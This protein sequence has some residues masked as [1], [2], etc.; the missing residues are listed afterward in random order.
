[1]IEPL[2]NNTHVQSV[3]ITMAEAFDV[4]DRGRFYDRTGAIRDVIQ[5]H[6]FQVLTNLAMEPPVRPDS[7]S[8]RD[9]KVKVLKAM[10]PLDPQN[11]VRGQFRG[12]R[13][14]T[15]W[16]RIRRSRPSLPCG[17]TSIP[18]A[19]RACRSTSGRASACR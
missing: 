5:N 3:Q 12:Y 15:G 14:E 4:A 13:T 9:E 1:M 18:G 16:R 7:E 10:E 11:V 19:G 2:L 8:I 6:L 17:S